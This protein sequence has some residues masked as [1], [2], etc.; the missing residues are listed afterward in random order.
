MTWSGAEAVMRGAEAVGS[1]WAM[2]PVRRQRQGLHGPVCRSVAWSYPVTPLAAFALSGAFD[3]SDAINA[4]NALNLGQPARPC[5][6]MPKHP[7]AGGLM[8]VAW[9][10]FGPQPIGKPN[11]LQRSLALHHSRRRQRRSWG[12]GPGAEP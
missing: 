4:I 3:K 6:P 10:T 2:V 9:S 5:P 12:T 8:I 7:R 1:T 11:G